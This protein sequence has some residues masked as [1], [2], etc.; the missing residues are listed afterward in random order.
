MIVSQDYA[1]PARRGKLR[2]LA[3][4]GCSLTLAMPGGESAIDGGVRLAPIPARGDPED[5]TSLAWSRRALGALL[6]DVRP[7]LVQI[8]LEPSS[9]A[10]AAAASAAGRLG[11]PTVVFSWEN[12]PR[13][14][15]W[16]ERR[17]RR[18][19]LH[20]ATGV[21]GGNLA[22]TALLHGQAPGALPATI[23]QFGLTLPDHEDRPARTGLAIG[24][25]GRLVAERGVDQLLR[26]CNQVMGHWSLAVLGTGPEQE[27]LEA[28]AQRLGLASRLRWLGG[29]GRSEVL[30][31]WDEVDVFVVP[32]RATP[33]WAERSN[34]LLVEA[35]ARG[36]TAVVMNTGALP[37]IVGD[38][39]LVVDDVESLALALQ[40]LLADPEL[41]RRLG[42]AG[43]KRVLAR[44][45]DAP[46]AE[47]TLD[48]WRR[49]VER[50]GRQLISTDGV[51]A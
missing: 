36:I 34:P 39:G 43:R 2:A 28:I 21:I 24:C 12:L 23:P 51:V 1:D 32:S 35:M 44:F 6:R 3:G 45:A 50:H 37:E 42:E 14:Y 46:V 20:T 8:E 27:S 38:A 13:A 31:L 29:A 5:P 9:Q 16:F 11:I 33:E 26:A 25:A 10:A 40:N 17:R 41:C 48:F 47:Q 7:D 18:A 49:V 22:A 19:A 15:S 4:L 30:K